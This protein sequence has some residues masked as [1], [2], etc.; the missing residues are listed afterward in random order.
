MQETISFG[1]VLGIPVG[2]H[3]SVLVMV[4]MIADSLAMAVLPALVPGHGPAEYWAT[5]ALAAA[6][7]VGALLAHELAHSLTARRFGL[8]VRRITLWMLGGL[9]LLGGEPKTPRAA[10]LIAVSGPATSLGLAL[11]AGGGAVVLQA[12]G[13]PA[14]VVASALWLAVM[15]AAL[16][17][18]NLLPGIPLDGGRV[19][20]AIV[21]H[22]YGDP[23][24]A[25]VA[26]CAAGR[27]VGLGI[28]AVGL[29]ELV[30]GDVSGLWLVMLGY[31][32][33]FAADTEGRATQ[34]RQA[35]GSTTVA[36]A[37]SAPGATGYASMPVERFGAEVASRSG[38]LAFPVVDLDGR[39]TGVVTLAALAKVPE[40]RRGSTVLADVQ[41]PLSRVPVAAPG[42][43]LAELVA[44]MPAGIETLALVIDGGRLVGTVAGYDAALVVQQ[45]SVAG[46]GQP[47][48]STP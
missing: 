11:F 42:D 31:V 17:L 37:M 1:R 5:A 18:F 30:A 35:L 20:G 34:L 19:L 15:N 38:R 33:V 40:A 16:G 27:V 6:F 21:W 13:A 46:S 41:V 3:W 23:D 10:F 28:G 26:A 7:F 48:A 4:I 24:R 39:P 9:S 29:V 32:I 47:A 12:V 25:A 22:R 43:L 2:A 44:R 45:A 14:L 8:P 36:E